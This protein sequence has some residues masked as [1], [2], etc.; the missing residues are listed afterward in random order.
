MHTR[1]CPFCG[2]ELKADVLGGLCPRC[3]LKQTLAGGAGAPASLA[4]AKAGAI[5]DAANATLDTLRSFGDYELLEKR[6][7]PR[8]SDHELS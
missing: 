3:V 6:N 4:A 2:E 8:N 5:L 7:G 1:T